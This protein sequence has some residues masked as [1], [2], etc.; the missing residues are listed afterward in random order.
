MPMM[1]SSAQSRLAIVIAFFAF[2]ISAITA[3]GYYDTRTEKEVYRIIERELPPHASMNRMDA[4]M[5]RHTGTVYNLDEDRKFEFA[6]L[7]PQTRI[8]K[9][10]FDRRVQIILKFDTKTRTL[11]RTEVHVGYTLL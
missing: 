2:F 8:D 4:F 1:S 11:Q 10:L 9:I 6:G 7:L 3:L 5:K